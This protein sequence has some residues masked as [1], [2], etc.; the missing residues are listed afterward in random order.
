MN[1]SNGFGRNNE[2]PG[3]GEDLG[4]AQ[5]LPEFDIE[6]PLVPIAPDQTLHDNPFGHHL[7]YPPTDSH[8]IRGHSRP[9]IY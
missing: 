7:H 3:G 6:F 9:R 4:V 5:F 8:G 2:I 1:T